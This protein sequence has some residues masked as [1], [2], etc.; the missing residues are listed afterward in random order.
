M[1]RHWQTI[2]ENWQDW[3]PVIHRMA[4]GAVLLA[5]LAMLI[6][7]GQMPYLVGSPFPA[8]AGFRMGSI[9]L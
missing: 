9:L 2:I 4:G 8:P 6:A 5:I 3:R 7:P 1:I